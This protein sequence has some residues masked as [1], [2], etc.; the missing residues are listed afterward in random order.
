MKRILLVAVMSMIPPGSGKNPQHVE[1]FGRIA[2]YVTDDAKQ[3]LRGSTITEEKG[4]FQAY[5]NNE[6]FYCI[7][8]VAPGYYNI[9]LE[10]IGYLGITAE[11]LLVISDSISIQNFI[12]PPQGI[13]MVD[14]VIAAQRQT[15][16]SY[17]ACDE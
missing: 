4:K 11:S 14:I 3:P 16:A 17:P 12:S 6:G 9:K 13:Q 7:K 1:R 8:E 10:C 15:T 5:T 2:G